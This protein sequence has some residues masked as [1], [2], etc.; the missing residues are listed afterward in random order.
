MK[1]V[2]LD[3]RAA[4]PGDLSW[5]GL[6]ALGECAI[7]DRTP[8]EKTVERCRGA[9]VVI[10]NKT[11]IDRAAIETLSQLR[12]IGVLATGYDV[13]DVEAAREK[14]IVVSNVPTYGAASVVQ[15]A[16]ALL[17]ELT[18]RVGLHDAGVH[19][20]RW[21]N[22]PDFSYAETPLVEIS[23]L[24]MGIVGFGRIGSA[25]A[26]A[27]RAF[28]MRVISHTEPPRET[29]GVTFVDLETVFRE[30]DVV[31]LHCPL[32]AETRGI[33]NDAR[34]RLMKRTA[35]LINTARGALVDEAALA[36]ALNEGRIAGAGVDVLSSEPPK[37][38]NPLLAAKNCVITPHVAWATR[39][40]RERLLKAA[41]EN[42]KAFLAG[43]PVNVVS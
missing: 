34:L 24:T 41:I 27:A 25:V 21:V 10:T 12:Y 31:T 6:E 30:S 22:S 19:K 28:G 17:L 4:N 38:E 8:R 11:V 9:E 32:T 3:A 7:Y 13:V 33:V 35:Y 36:R 15:A 39:A 42:V 26:E 5:E 2:V 14:G 40:A 18:N 43:R 1:I 37:A 23:G 20:G 29:E 16:F